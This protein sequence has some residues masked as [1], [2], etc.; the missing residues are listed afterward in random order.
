M[1]YA[2]NCKNDFFASDACEDTKS[3]CGSPD[4]SDWL[5]NNR[6]YLLERG[7]Q[8][9]RRINNAEIEKRQVVKL[10]NDAVDFDVKAS[11]VGLRERL[12]F[13]QDNIVREIK[14]R[15][16]HEGVEAQ[17]CA[18]YN[19]FEAV[20]NKAVDFVQE[21]NELTER[22]KILEQKR[23]EL[24]KLCSS[25]SQKSADFTHEY[26]SQASYSPEQ[27]VQSVVEKI[28]SDASR[29]L[30]TAPQFYCAGGDGA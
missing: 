19:Q 9:L 20:I 2:N 22:L 21:T 24:V 29:I 27:D 25:T 6:S 17:V 23:Q 13:A 30:A 12:A 5:Q 10:A 28:L 3:T 4:D 11:L 15:R 14:T 8:K 1:W 7:V 18:T 26:I 16:Q